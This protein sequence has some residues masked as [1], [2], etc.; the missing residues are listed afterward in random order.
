[1]VDVLLIVGMVLVVMKEFL[2]EIDRG[3]NSDSGGGM[4][5][6]SDVN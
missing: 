2:V 4:D 6:D 5:G 3:G 1:M